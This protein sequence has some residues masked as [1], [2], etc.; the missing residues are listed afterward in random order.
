MNTFAPHDGF[1]LLP[2]A[3]QA[4]RVGQCRIVA[5][6]DRG[7]ATALDVA[8][9]SGPPVICAFRTHRCARRFL[10]R[11]SAPLGT[12]EALRFPIRL[13]DVG[14][15]TVTILAGSP[16]WGFA[17]IGAMSRERDA[18][19]SREVL[20]RRRERRFAA[21]TAVH[22]GKRRRRVREQRAVGAANVGHAGCVRPVGSAG[23]TEQASAAHPEGL[24]SL[25]ARR[26]RR[27]SVASPDSNS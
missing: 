9:Q 26:A 4:D 17:A 24:R 18:R 22:A 10:S 1:G 14:S 21:G 27:R 15:V 16:R 19:P 25:A 6:D 3:G 2:G 12:R 13:A 23:T 8:Q 11:W 7:V 5:F 20:R